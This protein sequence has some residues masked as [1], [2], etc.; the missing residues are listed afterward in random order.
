MGQT[1]R[2]ILLIVGLAACATACT[3]GNRFED[4][5]CADDLACGESAVCRVARC[6]ASCPN[7]HWVGEDVNVHKPT[8]TRVAV[9]TGCDD[10]IRVKYESGIEERVEAGWVRSETA[11]QAKAKAR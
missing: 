11:A 2:G 6:R 1:Y 7:D 4:I 8:G 10:A 9:V 3:R 5:A